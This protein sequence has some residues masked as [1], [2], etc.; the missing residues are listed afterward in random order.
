MPENKDT[1]F[2]WED[3]ET[4]INNELVAT[5]GN[6]YHRVLTFTFKHFGE[7]PSSKARPRRRRG[8]RGHKSHYG[9]SRYRAEQLSFKRAL[10]A[11]MD[12]AQ[13]GN[14]YFGAVKP[15]RWSRRTEKGAVLFF[16]STCFWSRRWLS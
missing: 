2:S 14:R 6:F 9:H 4:K 11:I 13:Y 7:V 8:A 15:G 1:D 12:L 3:F 10:K 5:L 16:T